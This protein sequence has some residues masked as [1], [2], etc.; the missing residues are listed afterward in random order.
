VILQ[1]SED[2]GIKFY[3]IVAL[4]AVKAIFNGIIV[5][6]DRIRMDFSSLSVDYRFVSIME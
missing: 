3:F 1:P 2:K 4:S 6:K 5:S